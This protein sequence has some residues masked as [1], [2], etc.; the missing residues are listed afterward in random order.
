MMTKYPQS[1]ITS[2]GCSHSLLQVCINQALAFS[3]SSNQPPPED[4]CDLS[5]TK[6]NVLHKNL[7][8]TDSV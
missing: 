1:S 3:S 6:Q 5:K 7:K 8:T 2:A 4:K